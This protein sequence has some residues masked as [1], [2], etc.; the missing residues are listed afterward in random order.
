MATTNLAGGRTLHAYGIRVHIDAMLARRVSPNLVWAG[1]EMR[2]EG[3]ITMGSGT[4]NGNKE[5][6]TTP[7]PV[8]RDTRAVTGDEVTLAHEKLSMLLDRDEVEPQNLS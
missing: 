3:G 8:F 4:G 7:F 1:A 6:E 5:L 2:P